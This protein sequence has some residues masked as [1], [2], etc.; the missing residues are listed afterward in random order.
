MKRIIIV[1]SIIIGILII[2][3]E[4]TIKIPEEAIRFRIIANSNTEEDQYLKKEILNNL[5]SELKLPKNIKS[6]TEA[7]N[8]IKNNLPTYEEI[9]NDT[10]EKK[11]VERNF[12]INWGK[13][14]FPEKNYKNI[15]YKAGEYDSLVITLGEGKGKNFWCVLFPP[16]CLIDE[17]ENNYPSLVKE[18]LKKYF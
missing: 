4:E 8:Y 17:E 12:H 11:H 9:V 13:N 10:L 18:I 3:K 7:T 1:L 16:L 14:Y 2:N 5:Y 6:K 15:I